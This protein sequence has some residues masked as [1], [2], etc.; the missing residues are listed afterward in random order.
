MFI[1]EYLKSLLDLCLNENLPI[2]GRFA[3]M[4]F[5]LCLLSFLIFINIMIYFIVIININNEKFT[6]LI[7]KYPLLGRI[8]I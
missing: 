2:I 6:N 3:L 5:I 4:I 7:N 1:I 8:V